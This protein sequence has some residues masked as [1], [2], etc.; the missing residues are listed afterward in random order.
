[1]SACHTEHRKIQSAENIPVIALAGNPNCGKTTLFNLLTGAHQHVGNWPG[2]T[3]EQRSGTTQL[4]ARKASVMD[5]PGIYSLLG[6]GGED[7]TV[8]RD[9][10]LNGRVDLIVNIVDASNLE[11]HLVLTA[12]LL[13]TGRP[14]I[15]VLNMVDE[16]EARGLDVLTTALS[17]SLGLP[18]VPMVARTG[19]GRRDLLETLAQALETPPRGTP[20]TYGPLLECALDALAASMPGGSPGYRR[21]AALRLLE[22]HVDPADAAIKQV[23][24]QVT[25]DMERHGGEMPADLIM[26]RRFDWA[27]EG[28]AS[29]LRHNGR[30]GM[31]QR[32]TDLLDHVVL[33]DWLGVPVFLLTLYLIFVVSFSGGNIFLDFFDQASAALLIHG[34]GHVLLEAGLPPWLVSM[35]AG[36]AGGGLNLVIS[37]I[38]PI[39]LT[40]LFLALL[41]DSGYMAR[42]AYAMDRLMRRLG[43][44]GNALV[45]MIIGFGC[46][47]PAIMGSRIIEDPR[48]RLLTVLMQPF[49][50]CSARLTIYMAF[51]VVFFR[52][53]G[54]QVVFALYVL[55]IIVALLT[56]WL[57]G[58]TALPGEA[59]PFVM[60]LPPYRLP[61]VRSVLLQSWQR[62]KVFLFRVGRVIAAIGVVLFILPGVGWTDHGLQNTDINH[63]LLAQGSRALVPIFEPMGIRADNWPA[64]SGLIAGAAAKEIVIGTLNGIYQRQN[65]A[66]LM[67]NYRDPD[68]A[69]Q[70]WSA[71][72]TIPANALTFVTTLNDPLGL[73]AMG[74]VSAIEQSSGAERATLR[75]I[76]S[77]FTTLSAFAYLV[78]VLLYVP[79]ASTMGALRREV[80]WGWMGFS[81]C[82]G[83][84][85][86]WGASTVIYQTGTFVEH[87]ASSAACIAGVLVAFAALVLGLRIH[88]RRRA[89]SP[90]PGLFRGAAI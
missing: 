50:S 71:V 47:V 39:G 26:D 88:G 6:G 9:F 10:L 64:V 81:L 85:L 34:V 72:N 23:L 19:K 78:F 35:V 75:A 2:V 27:R 24:H 76:A 67:A 32:I 74:S 40:F 83:V 87:P 84:C 42:A 36:G 86:A 14:M 60:E 55:G 15:L 17:H 25:T 57:L 20:P 65:A 11:R 1:M 44:P 18:V 69:G 73:S 62:L 54:G 49:M 3:V 41:D 61:S 38:P 59:L 58:K 79:C 33:N 89:R 29:A 4:R 68:I 8:A 63:S 56:A 52:S 80:G 66:D 70:L 46:N 12:E 90:E 77:G 13:E 5:L 7:Q 28:A 22:G 43:L 53:N 21:C 82:Y 31:R 16:A 37:F 51:A 30:A 48:G 45:P